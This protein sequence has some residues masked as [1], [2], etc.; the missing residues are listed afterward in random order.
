[1]RRW[2]WKRWS[3][4]FSLELKSYCFFH[5][6]LNWW[7]SYINVN[8]RVLNASPVPSFKAL[9][10]PRLISWWWKLHLKKKNKM[11]MK[12][13]TTSRVKVGKE[14]HQKCPYLKVNKKKKRR[15]SK[16]KKMKKEEEKNRWIEFKSNKKIRLLNLYT[17]THSHTYRIQV[18]NGQIHKTR[19]LTT[20]LR[21]I[22]SHDYCYWISNTFTVVKVMVKC[23]FFIIFPF[24]VNDTESQVICYWI[25]LL[26]THTMMQTLFFY[27][28]IFLLLF[29]CCCF[30]YYFLS[31][32][33]FLM[34]QGC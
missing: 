29:L 7:C 27:N 19:L 17:Y 4:V 31:Y 9:P 12:K 11:K 26:D 1:M 8:S 13:L 33:F 6:F 15:R 2:G 16:R 10:D 23:I 20:G 32:Y 24:L 28:I 21:S 5:F 22:R 25:I 3:L 14:S 30:C 34:L 18:S